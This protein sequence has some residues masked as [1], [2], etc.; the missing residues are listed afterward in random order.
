MH[1]K[2]LTYI[3]KIISCISHYDY[4][5]TCIKRHNYLFQL[6]N[7]IS[8]FLPCFKSVNIFQ[9]DLNQGFLN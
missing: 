4:D 6:Q 1:I 3:Q 2:T 8:L 5:V 7:V 9:N